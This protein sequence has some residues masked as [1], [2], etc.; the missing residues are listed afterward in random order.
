GLCLL[1]DYP[2][3]GRRPPGAEQAAMQAVQGEDL[4]LVHSH[5]HDDHFD[6]DPAS[7]VRAAG[8]V[9]RLL[10]YDIAELAPHAVPDRDCLVVE[11]EEVYQW[12]GLSIEVL[13]SNDLGSAFLI[14]HGGLRIY[15]PGDLALWDWDRASE[16]E[17]AFTLRFFDEAVA[18][19]R[20][21]GP[22]VA[23]AVADP[24]LPS[25]AGAL[26]LVREVRPEI[27]VPMH[28]FGQTEILPELAAELD[29]PE[30]RVFLYEKSGD[31]ASFHLDVQERP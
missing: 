12:A 28:A 19:V 4:I 31:A 17:A 8:R 1:F 10:S 9:R 2:S 21:F 5:G 27:F 6:P 25:R 11:P 18:R 3:P 14:V 29:L 23:F 16:A 22:H 30:T 20:E 15:Y 26:R 7:V 24:R 13:D